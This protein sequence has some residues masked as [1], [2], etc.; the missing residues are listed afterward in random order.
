MGKTSMN[1]Q[2]IQRAWAAVAAATVLN[3][4]LGSIYAFS[5]F[6]R[7]IEA[8]LGLTR[9]A[10]SLVFGLATVAFTLGMLVTPYAYAL[11]SA[12]GL[13]AICTAAATIGITLVPASLAPAE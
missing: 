2:R 8:E 9:S 13:I 7:P 1:G 10:L 12:A 4:P 5:V 3:L 6:L 11:T